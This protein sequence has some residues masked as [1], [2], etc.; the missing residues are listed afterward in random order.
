MKKKLLQ[1]FETILTKLGTN[2]YIQII[3]NSP[4]FQIGG[5]RNIPYLNSVVLEIPVGTYSAVIYQLLNDTVV[6]I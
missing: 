4:S 1:I 5:A 6:K 2:Y 3:N